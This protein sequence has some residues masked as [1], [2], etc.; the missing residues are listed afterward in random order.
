MSSFHSPEPPHY[1]LSG[2]LIFTA[3]VL[4]ALFLTAFITRSLAVQY[5]KSS[6]QRNR[7][8]E[9]HIQTFS[10][11]S[12][13]SFSTLSYHML[14]YLII[15]YQSWSKIHSY[16]LPG[17]LFGSKSLLGTR[18]QRIPLHIWSW[19]TNSTLFADFATTICSSNA[20]FWWTQ[21]ALLITMAWSVFMS[22][23]GMYASSSTTR[24]LLTIDDR[25]ET[26]DT[27][28]MGIRKHQSDPACLFRTE[29]LFLS[30]A[31]LTSG[32]ER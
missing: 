30:Y 13:L 3:Y 4:S 2:A 24:T 7:G 21:Q 26:Q 18:A 10:T 31:F 5:K 9:K 14:N 28:P 29:S 19:L 23:E 25:S 16:Q 17:S 22:L 12:V 32:R 1:N 11:L 8:R 20:R 6:P 15:S 27:A